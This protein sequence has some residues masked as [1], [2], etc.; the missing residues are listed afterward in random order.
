MV[1]MN[2]GNWRA[3]LMSNFGDPKFPLA[4]PIS[5]LSAVLKY[6][7][8]TSMNRFRRCCRRSWAFLA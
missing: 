3:C 6:S 7:G 8:G 1:G 2:T 4:I 5:S